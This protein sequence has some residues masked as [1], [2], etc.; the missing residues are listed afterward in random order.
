MTDE[1]EPTS[2]T[3]DLKPPMVAEYVD[4]GQ[5][6]LGGQGEIRRGGRY[7]PSSLA[8]EGLDVSRSSSTV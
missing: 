1:Q 2:V 5:I 8:R 6:S 4:Q 7:E 3:G